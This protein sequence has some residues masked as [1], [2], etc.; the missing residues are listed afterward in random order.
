MNPRN[1]A[2]KSPWAFLALVFALSLPFWVIGAVSG[3]LL[4][5]LIPIKLPI[6]AL[7]FVSPV[8]AASILTYRESGP[9]GVRELLE[10]SVDHARI[11]RPIW[12]APMLLLWP[13]MMVLAY[14]LMATTGAA[15]PEPQL[16]I[17]MVPVFFVVFFFGAVC[18]EVGWQ[19]FAYDRLRGRRNA[20]EAGIILGAAW[21]ALHIVPFMQ[22]PQPPGWVVWQCLG[23]IPFRVL[24]VW[25]YNNTGSSVFAAI[26]FH[27]T[28]NVSQFL[29]PDYG[30]HYDPFYA[31]LIMAVVATAVVFVWG[32]ETLA[33][34]KYARLRRSNGG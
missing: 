31:F 7:M 34:F 14:G 15:L 19:G 23:M 6:S 27:A 11:G 16:P 3:D 33:R 28:A 32:P 13:G 9:G 21:G 12:Y 5:R 8:I 1:P 20:L 4:Q 2:G 25:L 26:V 30:S 10:R 29:F 18:E 22:I 24:I 17:L